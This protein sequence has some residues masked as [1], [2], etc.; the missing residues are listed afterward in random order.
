MAEHTPV[1]WYKSGLHIF[2]YH[3]HPDVEP[4][5]YYQPIAMLYELMPLGSTD[6]NARL[7]VAAPE[8]LA[9]LELVAECSMYPGVAVKRAWSDTVFAAIAKAKGESN[10]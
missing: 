7:I 10:G 9:A 2:H 8:M 1:P 3:P 5:G 6:S 4:P